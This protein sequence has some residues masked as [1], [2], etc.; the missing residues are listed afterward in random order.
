MFVERDTEAAKIDLALK[1]DFNLVDAFKLFDIKSLG[2]ISKQDLMD[3][4]RTNLEF[5]DYHPDTVTLFF[6]RYD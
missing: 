6:K 4:L 2:G 5:T 1:S 3:G